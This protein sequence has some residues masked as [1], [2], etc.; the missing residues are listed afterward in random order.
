MEKETISYADF[1]KISKNVLEQYRKDTKNIDL[2]YVP[3]AIEVIIKSFPTQETQKLC[4]EI[5]SSFDFGK[6][7]SLVKKCERRRF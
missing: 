5:F 7:I 4:Q 6:K 3:E 2:N 1:K